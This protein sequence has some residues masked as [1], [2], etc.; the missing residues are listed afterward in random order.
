MAI[1]RAA[2]IVEEKAQ[3]LLCRGDLAH[4]IIDAL[5]GNFSA[6]HGVGF[7]RSEGQKRQSAREN[8][9]RPA[10]RAQALPGRADGPRGHESRSRRT[11]S[12]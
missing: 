3:V 8:G 11:A 5:V 2:V 1:G 7:A 4:R 9:S 12:V 10:K 6:G